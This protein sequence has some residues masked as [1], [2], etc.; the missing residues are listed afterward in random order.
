MMTA[1]ML[2]GSIFILA[3]VECAFDASGTALA[4]P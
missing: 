4:Q 2:I 1:S 3:S